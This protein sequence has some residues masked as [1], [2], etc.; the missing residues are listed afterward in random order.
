MVTSLAEL[1]PKGDSAGN[2]S[3]DCTCKLQTRPL[4][5]E[6]ASREENRKCLKIFSIEVKKKCSLFTDGDLIPGQTGRL[7]VGP[8]ITLTLTLT[9]RSEG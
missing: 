2:V 6:G 5:K 8:K 7:T 3:S 1:G 9:L 4:V